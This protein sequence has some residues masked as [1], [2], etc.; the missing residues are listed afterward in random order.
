MQAEASPT[1][2]RDWFAQSAA[3]LVSST[4]AAMITTPV[5]AA[6]DVVIPTKNF[7][8]PLGMFAVTVP[9]SFFVLRR[10]NKGD[11]PNAKTGQGRRGSSIFTAGNMAK[12]EII[13]VERF[14]T[15]LLLEEYG[16]DATGDLDHFSSLGNAKSIANLI[17]LRRDRDKPN[18]AAKITDIE[19]ASYSQND[20]ILTFTMKQEI[21]VQKPEL[22]MET[23][24]VDRLFRI[25]TAKASLEA[26]D[27]NMMAVFASAL[28]SDFNGPDGAALKQVVDSFVVTN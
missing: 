9:E 22:L 12:A 8:D 3:L 25:T 14:P 7:V 1:S 18:G 27:G 4:A 28:E 16:I 6:E 26:T 15:K 17:N 5:F 24:G 21:D 23:Y 20:K 19:S 10:Q 13:A 2:R 11:L